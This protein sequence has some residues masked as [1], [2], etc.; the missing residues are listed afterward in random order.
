MCLDYFDVAR[1][2]GHVK[3]KKLNT[4]LRVNL[5]EYAHSLPITLLHVACDHPFLVASCMRLI[6]RYSN[7]Q[8]VRSFEFSAAP[9]FLVSAAKSIA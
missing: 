4:Y 7:L 2:R 5:I 1:Y 3:I 9:A 6:L 8:G